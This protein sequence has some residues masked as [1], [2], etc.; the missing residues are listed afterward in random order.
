MQLQLSLDYL[1]YNSRQEARLARRPSGTPLGSTPF[2]FRSRNEMEWIIPGLLTPAERNQN[3]RCQC[4]SRG[5]KKKAIISIKMT[6]Y[7]RFVDIESQFMCPSAQ[8]GGKFGP[9]EGKHEA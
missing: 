9:V 3:F 7:C 2:P 1:D 6:V 8:V 4:Q 5:A